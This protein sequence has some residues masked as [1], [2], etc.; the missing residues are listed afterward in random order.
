MILEGL[1]FIND[2]DMYKTYGVYL[3][4]DKAEDQS[5]YSALLKPADGKQLEVVNYPELN[6]E[7]LPSTISIKK[8]PRDVTLKLAIIA[9]SSSEWFSSYQ[10]FLEFIR[11][12]WLII[13][14][15]EI[16]ISF[17]M[18]YKSCKGYDHL[19]SFDNQI[20]GKIQIT[21]REPEPT[22]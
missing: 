22:I 10:A 13:R 20:A 15:P 1:F 7:I 5:N 14:L 3:C 16:A 17:K 4:E 18:Y 19:T 12:G 21:L 6:G 8:E 11:S 2:V 9:Q